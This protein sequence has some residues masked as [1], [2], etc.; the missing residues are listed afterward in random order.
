[1]S[2]WSSRNRLCLQ[3]QFSETPVRVYNLSHRSASQNAI[4]KHNIKHVQVSV[5]LKYT[6]LWVGTEVTRTWTILW[7]V[8][9][10]EV[11]VN[12]HL[13]CFILKDF[14][15]ICVCGSLCMRCFGARFFI[16]EVCPIQQFMLDLYVCTLYLLWTEIHVVVKLAH[17]TYAV[18][19]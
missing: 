4:A 13:I 14:K 12:Q 11:L 15:S 7:N 18:K 19:N 1:M 6:K 9:M 3:C 2:A 10:L 5:I 16:L 8:T 17:Y